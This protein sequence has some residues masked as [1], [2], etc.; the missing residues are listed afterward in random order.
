MA[1]KVTSFSNNIFPAYAVACCC[2]SLKK[3]ALA[4]LAGT[5]PNTVRSV[6]D[7][8]TLAQD[9]LKRYGVLRHTPGGTC[10]AFTPC[11]VQF[12]CASCPNFIPDPTRR[13]EVEEKIDSH[14]KAIQLF[15]EVG[16][17][18]QADVQKA[19]LHDW[20]RIEQEMIVLSQV[21]L[22]APPVERE[23]TGLMMDDLGEQLQDSLNQLPA[24]TSTLNRRL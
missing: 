12:K 20:R 2:F 9:A 22:L 23:L 17:Y 13:H 24:L 5:K 7:I 14:L 10:A 1:A 3:T 16:D 19:Y 8:Q 11:E 6:S 15:D 4:D 21:E 18:L